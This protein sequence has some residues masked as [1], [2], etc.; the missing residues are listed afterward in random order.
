MTR[1]K[2]RGPVGLSELTAKDRA[3]VKKFAEFLKDKE[4]LSPRELV[5]KYGWYLGYS[6]KEI[7]EANRK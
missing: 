4:K 6:E 5:C 1:R 3:E 2:D 7:A